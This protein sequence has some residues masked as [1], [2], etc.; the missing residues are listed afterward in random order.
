MSLTVNGQEARGSTA[1][2][3]AATQREALG[4]LRS[5][6]VIHERIAEDRLRNLVTSAEGRE[7]AGRALHGIVLDTMGEKETLED[8]VLRW[9]A[10]ERGER[11]A[12]GLAP[13]FRDLVESLLD[14]KR[15]AARSYRRAAQS[16]PD[17]DIARSL[18]RLARQA[19][20]HAAILLTILGEAD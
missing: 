2:R 5:L 18:E 8:V 16:A 14:V 3:T 10:I 7:A 13:E 15:N 11:R 6:L 19:G 9:E 20:E 12:T 4:S 1:V 17:D